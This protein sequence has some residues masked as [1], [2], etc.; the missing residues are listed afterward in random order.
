MYG[1]ILNGI[2]IIVNMKRIVEETLANG[3]K[4]Y[5]V[6][7]NKRFFGLITCN[8]YTDSYYIGEPG[9]EAHV[10]AVFGSLDEAEIFAFGKCKSRE[11]VERKVI[12]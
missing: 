4:Q 9:V 11:V 10:D 1:I 3:E 7:T 6:E 8:W 12:E 2:I 5:R